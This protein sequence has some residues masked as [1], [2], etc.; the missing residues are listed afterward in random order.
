M[1]KRLVVLTATMFVAAL[2]LLPTAAQALC[3]QAGSIVS[4]SVQSGTAF[5][6]I[7][8]RNSNVVST[9]VWFATTTDPKMVAAAV[10]ALTGQARVAMSGN[11]GSC[12][13]SGTSRNMGTA[14]VISLAP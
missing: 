10:G 5:T 12:P 2:S 11:A 3:T 8:L 6:S 4:V 13:T 7:F 14:V 9:F 1:K